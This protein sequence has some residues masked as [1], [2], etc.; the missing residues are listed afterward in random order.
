MEIRIFE[1]ERRLTRDNN[2]L[3][4]F[5]LSGIPPMPRGRAKIDITYALDANGILLVTAVEKS[6]GKSGRITITNDKGRLSKGD[7]ERM[8]AD[9]EKFKVSVSIA[10]DS[11]LHSHFFNRQ[12][13]TKPRLVLMP[14]RPW[15]TTR[16]LCVHHCAMT[17][18]STSSP[19]RTGACSTASLTRNSNGSSTILKPAKRSLSLSLP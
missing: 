12:R 8:V 17:P 11:D 9:A 13:T 6:T 18:L 10:V 5:M 16:P 4:K 3:G 1:G 15:S 19:K 2:L 7:I 14:G